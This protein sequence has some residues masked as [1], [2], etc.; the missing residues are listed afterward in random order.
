MIEADC[1]V[2]SWNVWWRF[3]DWQSRQPLIAATVAEQAADLIMLQEAWST[4]DEDQPHQLAEAAGLGHVAWSPNRQPETW[5]DRLSDAPPDLD[6]GLAVIS[7]WPILETTEIMLPDG[8][9]PTSGRTALGALIDHPRGPLPVVT[10]HLDPHPARS[11]LRVEQLNAVA[12]M[13]HRIAED[14]GPEA[15]SPIIC[16]DF[17]AEPHSDEVRRFSGL[18]TAPHIE[19]LAFQDAWHVAGPEADPGWTWRKECPYIAAGNPNARI[20]YVFTGMSGRIAAAQLVGV[21][22]SEVWPSDHAGVLADLRP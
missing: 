15:L 1:R 20:D 11:A 17:N 19:D 14:A 7:R 4:D 16:G 9:W 2:L 18:Q 8:T 3:G 12:S 21:T 6:C 22:S 5:C 13:I 10:T